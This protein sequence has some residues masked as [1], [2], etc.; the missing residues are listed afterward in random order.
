VDAA[1][2][3]LSQA[4]R[5]VL[6]P[7]VADSVLRQAIFQALPR[8]ELEKQPSTKLSGWRACQRIYP[9]RERLRVAQ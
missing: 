3:Q 5:L 7:D 8:E 4:C 2:L 9:G 6:H 1:A